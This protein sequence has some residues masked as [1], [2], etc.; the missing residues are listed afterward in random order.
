M[1]VVHTQSCL[2][3]QLNAFKNSKIKELVVTNSILLPE[4]KKIEKDQ[5]VICR[6]ITRRSDYPR[7]R[8]KQSVSTLFD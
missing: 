2:V 8:K 4:E 1:H 3:L 7:L 5:G 6:P